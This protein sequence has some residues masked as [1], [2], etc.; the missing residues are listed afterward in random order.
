MTVSVLSPRCDVAVSPPVVRRYGRW[1][2]ASIAAHALVLSM[3]GGVVVVRVG[4]PRP[5]RVTIFSP[6]APPPPPL[7]GG[8]APA[9]GVVP[10]PVVAPP[11]PVPPRPAEKPRP[12]KV[13]RQPQPRPAPRREVA[14][15]PSVEPAPA[16]SSDRADTP[17]QPGLSGND[18]AGVR[19]GVSGGLRGGTVG[20]RGDRVLRADEVAT[21]PVVVSSSMPV[22]PPLA[23]ARG[24]EGLVVLETVVDRGGRVEA[25]S[26]R[27]VESVPLLD[28]AAIEALHKWRFRPGRD[29]HGDPVRVLVHVPVRFRLR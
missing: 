5:I 19:G 2:M 10:A 1:M 3:A 15:E 14:P 13:T 29:T 9:P 12:Q 17:P 20:G 8:V 25:E 28:D 27:V 6:S 11:E 26:V 4:E 18:A 22:Y 23:R 24:I 7:G 16:P 21:P